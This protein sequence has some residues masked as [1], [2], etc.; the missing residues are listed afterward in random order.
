MERMKKLKNK[1]D[2]IIKKKS[3]FSKLTYEI[4]I[5]VEKP[6]NAHQFPNQDFSFKRIDII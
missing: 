4:N 6:A 3:D 5:A 1:L 2:G